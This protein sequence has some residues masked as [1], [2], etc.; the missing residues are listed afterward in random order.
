MMAETS[1]KGEKGIDRIDLPG[2]VMNCYNPP[3]YPSVRVRLES[4]LKTFFANIRGATI[5]V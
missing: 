3:E 2:E 4:E 5:Q 1:F